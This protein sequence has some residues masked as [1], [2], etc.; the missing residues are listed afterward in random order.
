[1]SK[2][3]NMNLDVL[4][5]MVERQLDEVAGG[6]YSQWTAHHYKTDDPV[7]DKQKPA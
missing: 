4:S 5:E 3:S 7:E 2:P 1:M 6:G